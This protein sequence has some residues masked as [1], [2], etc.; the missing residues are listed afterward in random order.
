MGGLDVEIRRAADRRRE[1]LR[2]R[3][4]SRGVSLGS[5]GGPTVVPRDIGDGATDDVIRVALTGA[6]TGDPEDERERIWSPSREL[7]EP[8][9]DLVEV[10]RP[11]REQAP[12]EVGSEGL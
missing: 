11:V 8:G 6:G 4:E 9:P 5:F 12:M 7:V 3:P 2:A 1:R 10:P